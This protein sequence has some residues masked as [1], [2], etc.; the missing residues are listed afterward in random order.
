M[1][2][3]KVNFDYLGFSELKMTP[4]TI[5]GSKHQCDFLVN[6]FHKDLHGRTFSKGEVTL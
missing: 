4:R 6:T 1:C 5:D 3:C 2:V